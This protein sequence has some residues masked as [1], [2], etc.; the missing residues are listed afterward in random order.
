MTT[1]EAIAR[2]N[3][4]AKSIA[5]Y[6]YERRLQPDQPISDRRS[7]D[8]VGLNGWTFTEEEIER[9]SRERDASNDRRRIWNGA[10]PK[11]LLHPIV[12]EELSA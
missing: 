10:K 7:H 11:Y 5:R 6:V 12:E 4:G 1:A 2:L 9:F 3:I 8:G